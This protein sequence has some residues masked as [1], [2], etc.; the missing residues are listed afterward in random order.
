MV[1]EGQYQE[2]K[3][4]RKQPG[5]IRCENQGPYTYTAIVLVVLQGLWVIV[6]LVVE[7]PRESL[8][9][10]FLL[11]GCNFLDIDASSHLA[12]AIVDRPPEITD[13]CEHAHTPI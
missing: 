7:E 3:I 11:C 13:N 5:F 9:G 6:F 1:F 2:I 12:G 4:K 8:D 10:M